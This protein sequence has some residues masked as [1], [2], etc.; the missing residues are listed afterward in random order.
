[1]SLALVLAVIMIVV[2]APVGKMIRVRATNFDN[3][4]VLGRL[5]LVAQADARVVQANPTTNFGSSSVLRVNG[6]ITTT[7]TSYIR[8]VVYDLPTRI[9]RAVVRVY[10][11]SESKDGVALYTTG[12]TWDEMQVTWNTR[13]API[14]AVLSD[15]SQIIANSWIEYPVTSVV[16]GSGSYSFVL[17]AA[18]T[19]G[20]HFSSRDGEFPPQLMLILASADEPRRPND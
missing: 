15:T 1:M 13:P 6:G 19:D 20:V 12:N 8:F 2:A 7:V 14:T 5:L 10:A 18:S 9:E 17:A 4:P 16:T 3:D 11:T